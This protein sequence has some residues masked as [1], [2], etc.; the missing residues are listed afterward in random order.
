[1]REKENLLN[2][3]PERGVALLF[4]LLALLLLS[5][6]AAAL[7]FMTTTETSVNYNYRSE[8]VAYFG[9]KAGVEEV[10]DRMMAANPASVA[11]L[12]PAAAPSSTGGVLYLLNE[13]N[14]PG[15]VQ[16]WTQSNAYV[17]DELCH[18]GYTLPGLQSQ[19][20]VAPDIRCTSVPTGAA[21]Y[22]TTTSNAP[23]NGTSAA[24]AYKWVRITLKLNGSVQSYPANGSASA[25]TQVCWNGV[26]EVLLQAPATTCQALVP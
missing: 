12:L 22:S 20:T 2:H 10:R 7:M 23:W 4:A 1:M 19:S 8:R 11:A 15:S 9:A 21:W 26:S 25:T 14:A 17:D 13:G 5:A 18:D 6:I 16:P 3:R 24:L